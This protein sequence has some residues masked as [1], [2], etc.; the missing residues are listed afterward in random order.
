MKGPHGGIIAILTAA[1]GSVLFLAGSFLPL[2]MGAVWGPLWGV[3]WWPQGSSRSFGRI[4]PWC[5]VSSW[6]LLLATPISAV[7][8]L[9]LF[10]LLVARVLLSVRG[11]RR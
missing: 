1:L 4:G 9:F 11:Q 8:V 3:E 6:P 7:F 10:S 5:G 2:F